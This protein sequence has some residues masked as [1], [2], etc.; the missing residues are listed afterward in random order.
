[1][2][3]NRNTALKALAGS[4]GALFAGGMAKAGMGIKMPGVILNWE[5]S[6]LACAPD[7]F[8]N[9]GGEPIYGSNTAEI[10]L[11]AFESFTFQYSG[12]GSKKV[13]ITGKEMW[14]AINS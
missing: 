11:S 3:I 9:T 5:T 12:D 10:D 2:K 14:D 1:M 6:S 13:T 4:I 8:C 7:V